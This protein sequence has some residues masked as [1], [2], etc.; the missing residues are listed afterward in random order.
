MIV[1]LWNCHMRS[2]PSFGPA[3]D[4]CPLVILNPSRPNE[5]CLHEPGGRSLPQRKEPRA[6]NWTYN[7][8]R[9]WEE[10]A[11]Q[12]FIQLLLIETCLSQEHRCEA[13]EVRRVSEFSAA[14]FKRKEGTYSKYEVT[15]QGVWS[16][17]LWIKDVNVS[18]V[19]YQQ[20]IWIFTVSGINGALYHFTS[21]LATKAVIKICF[22]SLLEFR[23]M[24]PRLWGW[25]K[26]HHV[27]SFWGPPFSVFENRFLTIWSLFQKSFV[28]NH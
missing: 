8:A 26:S 1:S 18:T 3:V 20:N 9:V 14:G 28:V 7:K 21:H 10:G 2:G 16:G 6:E 25:A 22:Q 4:H 12:T 13:P 19:L 5:T 24:D 11:L 23:I 17:T 27:D 15:S